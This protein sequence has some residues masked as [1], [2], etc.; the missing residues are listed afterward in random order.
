MKNLYLISLY[1]FAISLAFSSDNNGRLSNNTD[2]KSHLLSAGNDNASVSKNVASPIDI[3]K[4]KQS[5]L[6][7]GKVEK[8]KSQ[9]VLNKQK[10]GVV[11]KSQMLNPNIELIGKELKTKQMFS[12]RMGKNM[13]EKFFRKIEKKYITR[14]VG[15]NDSD[16]KIKFPVKTESN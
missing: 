4:I 6:A 2:N 16:K 12:Q 3:E 9:Q 11:D 13:F 7:K 14:S 15:D 1:F 8:I 10:N 5:R